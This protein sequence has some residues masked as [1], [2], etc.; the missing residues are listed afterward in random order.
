MRQAPDSPSHLV[1]SPREEIEIETR[2]I[3]N[4]RERLKEIEGK[5]SM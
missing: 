1:L 4:M 2:K 3:A 5:I